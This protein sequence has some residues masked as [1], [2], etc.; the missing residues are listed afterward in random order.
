MFTPDQI[1]MIRFV[2]SILGLAGLFVL[3]LYLVSNIRAA[4]K[5]DGPVPE[6]SIIG[7][8]ASIVATVFVVSDIFQHYL[9]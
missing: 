8:I 2:I 7:L 9:S 5:N 4:H 1:V 6:P 3:M